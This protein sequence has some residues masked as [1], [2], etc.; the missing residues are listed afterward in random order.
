[1]PKIAANALAHGVPGPNGVYVVITSPDVKISGFCTSFRAYHN[2]STTI[3]SGTTSVTHWFP[4]PS[5][6]AQAATAAL[7][8]MAT[9]PLRTATCARIR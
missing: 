2:T 6:G 9:R 7:R 8:C 5:R 1:M 4:I 3:V